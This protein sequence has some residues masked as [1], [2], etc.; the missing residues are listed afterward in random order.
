M[1][2]PAFTPGPWQVCR[3]FGKTGLIDKVGGHAIASVTGYYNSA[4]QTE[5]NAN[6]IAAAPDGFAAAESLLEVVLAAIRLGHWDVD[7]S[8]DPDMAIERT[9]YFLAKARGETP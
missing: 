3:E 7:G 1:N 8:C 5:A 9:K 2:A 6:L 4:G